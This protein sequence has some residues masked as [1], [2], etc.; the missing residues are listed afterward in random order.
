MANKNISRQQLMDAVMKKA[1]GYTIE[2][3]N[4]E[5]VVNN[6]ELVLSKRKTNKKVQPPDM[7]ALQFLIQNTKD[8]G[9]FDNMTDEELINE[10]MRL[11]TQLKEDEK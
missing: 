3:V 2:E 7:S 8:E 5:Y 6:D 4:E 11:L 1:L 10:K 9:E